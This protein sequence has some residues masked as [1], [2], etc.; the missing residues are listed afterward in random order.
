MTEIR[1]KFRY[2]IWLST[3]LFYKNVYSYHVTC[4]FPVGSISG[5]VSGFV[6]KQEFDKFLKKCGNTET[7]ILHYRN[8]AVGY[9]ELPVDKIM[10]NYPSIQRIYWECTGVCRYEYS[11]C[12]NGKE[13]VVIN[14]SI[15]KEVNFFLY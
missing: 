7:L 12:R 15:G 13:P 2:L 4:D 11:P 6:G 14:C 1:F 8:C 5:T 3:I 9:L 10:D